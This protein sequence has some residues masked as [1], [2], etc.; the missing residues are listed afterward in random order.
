MFHKIHSKIHQY[1]QYYINFIIIIIKYN[2]ILYIFGI[3]D[4]NIFSIFDQNEY[5]RFDFD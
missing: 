5:I 1:Q 3:V 2:F 4:I